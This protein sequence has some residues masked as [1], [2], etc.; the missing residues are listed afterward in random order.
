MLHYELILCSLFILYNVCCVR[1]HLAHCALA[2]ISY[3]KFLSKELEQNKHMQCTHL[4]LFQTSIISSLGTFRARYTFFAIFY[5][6][7]PAP[8]LTST[9]FGRVVGFMSHSGKNHL[10]TLNIPTLNFTCLFAASSASL[11]ILP[12]THN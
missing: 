8:L 7:A 2:K 3:K 4:K 12:A 6:L 11:R 9:S 5:Q 1:V 10:F